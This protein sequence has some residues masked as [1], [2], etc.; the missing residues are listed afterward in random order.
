MASKTPPILARNRSATSGGVRPLDRK[1]DARCFSTDAALDY[2][3][4][5]LEAQ[6]MPELRRSSNLQQH[7]TIRPGMYKRDG[8]IFITTSRGVSDQVIAV[9]RLEKSDSVAK[10]SRE[11]SQRRS[12]RL[13]P[14]PP[15]P[16]GANQDGGENRR[17][18]EKKG[19]SGKR[20]RSGVMQKIKQKSYGTHT[21]HSVISDGEDTQS[22]P[23]WNTYCKYN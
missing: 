3:Q 23:T 14:P 16:H 17:D 11:G 5:S 8:G 19:G 10:E 6:D 13:L 4:G 12:G 7:P 20:V 18:Y 2:S 15:A 1:K 21:Q 22:V 9:N